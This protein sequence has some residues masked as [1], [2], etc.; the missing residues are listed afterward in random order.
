MHRDD[1]PFVLL[2]IFTLVEPLFLQRSLYFNPS[3]SAVFM[4]I[5][6]GFGEETMFRILSLAIVILPVF[7]HGLHDFISFTTDPSLSGEGILTQQPLQI[8]PMP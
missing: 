3:L 7:A 2:E 4:G 5:A 6:A 8:Q 1:P